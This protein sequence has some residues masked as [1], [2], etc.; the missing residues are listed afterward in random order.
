MRSILRPPMSMPRSL[1]GLS[2]SL[3]SPTRVDDEVNS[4]VADEVDAEIA[5]EVNSEIADIDS[6]VASKFII[7]LNVANEVTTY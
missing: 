5:D 6:K 1:T 4:E 3:T 2:W 7:I